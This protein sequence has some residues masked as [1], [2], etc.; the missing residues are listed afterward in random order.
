[1]TGG[2]TTGRSHEVPVSNLVSFFQHG[3]HSWCATGWVAPGEPR[4]PIGD[5][6]DRLGHDDPLHALDDLPGGSGLG[7]VEHED[8]TVTLLGALRGGAW[9]RLEDG[10]LVGEYEDGTGPWVTLT[11]SEQEVFDQYAR[12]LAQHLGRR[13]G[14]PVRLWASWYSYYE[15]VTETLMHETLDGLD[16]LDLDIIQLDDGWER[17]IGDWT[18]NDEFPSGL[19]DLAD[20]I[21]ATGRRAG[22]WLAPFIA[23]PDSRIAQDRPGLILRDDAGDPVVAGINWGGPYWALDVTREETLDYLAELFSDLHEAGYDFFKLD[24]IYAAG[25]P[26]HHANPMSRSDAYRSA[27]L[28]IREAVGD[29]TYLLACGAPIIESIGVFDGIRIGPDVGPVW[30][31]GTYAAAGR[32]MITAMH[33]LWLRPAIDPDPDV[34]FFRNTDLSADTRLHLQ[35]M[36]HVAGFLGTSDPPAWLLDDQRTALASAFGAWP[37]TRQL[38]RYRWQ[39]ADR[40]VDFEPVLG[41]DHREPQWKSVS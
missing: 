4:R 31:D 27:C 21:H 9:V 36:A 14:N 26:G 6:R 34:V 16:G 33:R 30:D 10:A 24:F 39:V 19:A 29:A 7:A 28:R 20:R 22:L 35:D 25:F 15:D 40:V 12:R 32:S 13:G 1:M 38:S 23:M 37:E 2:H 11:G 5:E 41:A 3:W 8:G 18:P 17:A